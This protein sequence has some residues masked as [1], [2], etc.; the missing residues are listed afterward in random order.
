[1]TTTCYAVTTGE[2]DGIEILAVYV[3]RAD[4]ERA[5]D[6]IRDRDDDAHDPTAAIVEVPLLPAGDDTLRIRHYANAYVRLAEQGAAVQ[7]WDYTGHDVSTVAL[8]ERVD[9]YR[10]PD[11]CIGWRACAATL[12]RARQLLDDAL[13]AR[14]QSDAAPA[15]GAR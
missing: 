7:R 13:A 4:A 2:Y 10:L 3:D 12:E 5:A 11:D 6:R 15:D 14:A 9:E 1:M 8:D